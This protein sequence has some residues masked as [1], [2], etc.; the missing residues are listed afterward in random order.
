MKL[1]P[2]CGQPNE[3]TALFCE[4]CGHK[5]NKADFQNQATIDLSNNKES[6]TT[7]N[8]LDIHDSLA[9]EQPTAP[10]RPQPPRRTQKNIWLIVAIIFLVILLLSFFFKQPSDPKTTEPTNQS[11]TEQTTEDQQLAKYDAIVAEAKKLTIDGKYKE[12]QLKLAEIPV[13]VLGKNQFLSIK[14]AVDDLT[15]TNEQG[16][17]EQQ[18]KTEEE[19][20]KAEEHPT[21]TGQFAKWANTYSFYYAQEGQIQRTLTIGANGSVKQ[22]N[23]DGTQF[24]GQATIASASGA[25]PSYDTEELYPTTLP[26]TKIVHPDVKITIQWENGGETQ[27]LYGY[28]SYSSHLALT[29]GE[30]DDDAINEV[31]LTY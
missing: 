4:Q 3:E 31:W 16:Q 13:S 18:D 12:S 22:N 8:E 27:V 5:L 23:S 2:N 17:K 7:N 25:L 9:Q 19:D 1:C 28:L 29:D 10:Q 14:E 30:E 15:V 21:F 26:A 20:Q 6:S 11:T 24:F